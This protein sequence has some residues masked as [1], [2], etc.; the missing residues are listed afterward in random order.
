MHKFFAV[1]F[2][3]Q[4]RWPRRP[5]KTLVKLTAGSAPILT[6]TFA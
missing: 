4:R 6:G 1:I 2:G 3:D 5:V